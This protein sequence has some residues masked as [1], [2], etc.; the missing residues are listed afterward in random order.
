MTSHNDISAIIFVRTSS[1]DPSGLDPA[2]QRLL[3][4]IDG[5]TTLGR[6]STTLGLEPN[7][8]KTALAGLLKRKLIR[9]LTPTGQTTAAEPLGRDGTAWPVA[10][11]PERLPPQRMGPSFLP[12][13]TECLSLAIGPVAEFLV[14]DTLAEL[15]LDPDRL[16]AAQAPELVEALAGE[17]PR[18]DRRVEFQ[19]AM[20]DL[21]NQTRPD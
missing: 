1:G 8:L 15:G 16:P 6:M 19:K 17:I 21:L 13:L 10:P 14:E 11:D 18:L 4:A 20:L 7:R 2:Q 5:R 3:E 12:L 9:P